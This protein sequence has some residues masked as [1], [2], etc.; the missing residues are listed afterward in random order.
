[1]RWIETGFALSFRSPKVQGIIRAAFLAIDTIG[2]DWAIGMN[3]AAAA[4]R[5]KLLLPFRLLFADG[6][7]RRQDFIPILIGPV[8]RIHFALMLRAIRMPR[9]A[10]K[11]RGGDAGSE[12]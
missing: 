6:P 12:I 7:V 3:R 9:L 10:A 11:T 4:Y 2:M 8:H 5:A 1:M